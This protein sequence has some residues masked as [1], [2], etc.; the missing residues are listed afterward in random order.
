MDNILIEN[1]W[2]RRLQ[3]VANTTTITN[4]IIR[5]CIMGYNLG[6]TTDETIDLLTGF[7]SNV[8][9]ANNVIYGSTAQI[10]GNFAAEGS[11]TTDQSTI[12]NN[13]FVHQNNP[14]LPW[15][16]FDDLR[17]STVKNNIFFSDLTTR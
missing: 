16:A 11:V 15:Y 4:L 5:N 10:P 17:N 3:H 13:L 6:G 8:V 1:S 7:V 9:I 2:V 14:N 12:E